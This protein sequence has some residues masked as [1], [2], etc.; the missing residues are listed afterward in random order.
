VYKRQ[1][2][3]WPARRPSP[4]ASAAR[5][6]PSRPTPPCTSRSNW[7]TSCAA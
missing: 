6:A 2:P 7:S 4:T 5:A 3:N 1:R